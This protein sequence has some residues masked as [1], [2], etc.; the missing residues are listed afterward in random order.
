MSLRPDQKT[1][2]N[3]VLGCGV[4]GKEGTD[5]V[6][7]HK[8]E[9]LNAILDTFQAHGQYELDSART[10]CTGTSEEL[11]GQVR[12]QERGLV[13]DTKLYP[14]HVNPRL[15]G[16]DGP[17]SHGPEDLRKHLDIALK[18]LKT[19]TIDLWYLH[20]PDRTTPYEE[21]LKAVNELYH[22]GKFKRFGI[23]NFM[24]WEVAEIV[25]IC[26]ARGYVVPS[27]YQGVYNA[28]HRNVEPELFPCLRK[29]GIAFYAYS[30][31]GGGLFTGRYRSVNDTLEPG[32]RFDPSSGLSQSFRSVYW[33]EAYF[34][35]L[36]S[37]EAAAQKYSLTMGE[38][39]LRWL[40]HHSLLRQEHGDAIIIGASSNLVDLEKD[41]LPEAV[42]RALD[43]A[44]ASVK[45]FASKYFH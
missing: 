29:F 11:I 24:S 17:I 10:Y 13:I 43:D 9:D 38:V 5:G 42:V 2:L 8:V 33:K 15:V 19:N 4:F 16:P 7:V 25:G 44:W 18:A 26:K 34:T 14:T 12:W 40:S 28:M 32:T 39:A 45:P 3:I 30:P 21:T 6:R 22:E 31:L 23:S 35:A 37:V 36:T 1:A 20:G 41:P 27:V